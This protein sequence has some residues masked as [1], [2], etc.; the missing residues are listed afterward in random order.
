LESHALALQIVKLAAYYGVSKGTMASAIT[1]TMLFRMGAAIWGIVADA[2]GRRAALTT[3]LWFLALMQIASIYASTF[4]AF[5]ATRAF[6][7][8][9]MGGIFGCGASRAFE[10]IP[11]RARG[12]YSGIFQSAFPIS[13]I[14]AAAA[15]LAIGPAH[16]PTLFAIGAG[17]SFAVGCFRAILPEA[18]R[19]LEARKAGHATKAF[20][21]NFRKMM[22]VDWP[23]MLYI[24][25][26]VAWLL[27]HGHALQDSYVTFLVTSK[28][29]NN[30]QASRNAIYA[31]LGATFGSLA[32]AYFSQSLGRRRT[33]I[34]CLIIA[35]AVLPAAVIPTSE[36]AL[37]AGAFWL[38]AWAQSWSVIPIYLSEICHP[39]WRALVVGLSYQVGAALSSPTTQVVN[40]LAERFHTITPEGRHVEAYGPVMAI[41]SSIAVVV[42]VVLLAFG[43]ERLGTRFEEAPLATEEDEGK[44]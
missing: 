37:G 35:A 28:G 23:V 36:G 29:F 6:F 19:Y 13:Y 30:S 7:G 33:M 5:L 14:V 39:S 8:V 10:S 4:P 12:V 24:S 42:I 41:V 15:N 40:I 21:S 43:P 27:V 3:N 16:W 22:V 1:L 38:Q 31:K 26:L 32:I 25:V 20:F 2:F 9:G 34:V 18:P 17:L 11:V 44:L